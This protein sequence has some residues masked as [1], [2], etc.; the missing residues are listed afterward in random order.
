M[1]KRYLRLASIT[2]VLMTFGAVC[3]FPRWREDVND[4]TDSVTEVRPFPSRHISLF[5]ALAAGVSALLMLISA[6]W[7]H[8]ASVSTAC[9]VEKVAVGGIVTD[10][11]PAATVLV[12]ISVA[13]VAAV[14]L[15]LSSMIWENQTLDTLTDDD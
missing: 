4:E 10:V 2:L 7:Q 5:A 11:G 15:C 12:W 13:A 6:L 8:I 14:F 9:I 3:T 1:L